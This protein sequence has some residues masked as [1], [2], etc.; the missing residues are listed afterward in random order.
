VAE[1]VVV[2]VAANASAHIAAIS[3][4]IL[5]TNAHLSSARPVAHAL[6]AAL[7]P[8]HRESGL[9]PRAAASMDLATAPVAR[10]ST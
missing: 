9:S 2:E 6:G 3:Q 1:D 10:E 5:N 8:R 4:I 7:G